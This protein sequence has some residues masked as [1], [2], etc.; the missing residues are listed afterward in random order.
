MIFNDRKTMFCLCTNSFNCCR[1]T[2][3]YFLLF[4]LFTKITVNN[5]EKYWVWSF[6]RKRSSVI[7]FNSN[8]SL[9][10]KATRSMGENHII[11]QMYFYHK[12]I[13]YSFYR[14]NS[15]FF[16]W[17]YQ[18]GFI[19]IIWSRTLIII[20]NI[21]F[22]FNIIS[23]NIEDLIRLYRDQSRTIAASLSET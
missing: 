2:H 11:F 22:V 3:I 6:L 17:I 14:H 13:L 10:R 9:Y 15:N 1:S 4:L 16:V 19:F 20:Y 5:M 23:C 7:F 8:C 12:I 18:F 21:V